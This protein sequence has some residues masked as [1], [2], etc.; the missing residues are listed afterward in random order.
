MLDGGPRDGP[1]CP[2][3]ARGASA[4]P[5]R[6]SMT[7][8]GLFVWL[9]LGGL[10]ALGGDELGLA[11]ADR[12]CQLVAERVADLLLV[13]NLGE[14]LRV[15]PLEVAVEELLEGPDGIDRHVV[16]QSLAAGEDDRHLLLDR[17]RLVLA[18][19]EELDHALTTGQLR[20]GRPVE[21]GAELREGR[22]LSILGEVEPKLAGHL[23]HGLDLR[24]STHAR[25]READVH[26]RPDATIE[27]VGLQVDLE[28]DLFYGGI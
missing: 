27:Q 1:P 23:P 11:L 10:D 17:Q 25:D 5:W 15:T 28:S 21:V 9:H 24:R 6:P 14:H 18:L 8:V 7:R 4:E 2:P 19:L 26:G 13:A 20:L 3:D 16:E 22:E 12:L